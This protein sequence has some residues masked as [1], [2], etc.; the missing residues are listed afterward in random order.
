VEEKKEGDEVFR[1][2]IKKLDDFTTEVGVVAGDREYKTVAVVPVEYR[3]ACVLLAK[4][5]FNAL[6]ELT[7]V[8][9]RDVDTAM[10]FPTDKS[11]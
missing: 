2:Y 7:G 3:V 5:F 9:F 8:V 4:A 6:R 10:L 1:M 11:D